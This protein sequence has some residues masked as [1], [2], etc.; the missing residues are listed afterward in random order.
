[1]QKKKKKT[2]KIQKLNVDFHEIIWDNK[3]KK[4]GGK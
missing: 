3:E 1:M 2:L 4:V